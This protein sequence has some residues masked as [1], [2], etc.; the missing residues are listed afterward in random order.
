MSF[1]NLVAEDIRLVILK[2]LEQDV[3]YSHNEYVIKRALEYFGHNVSTDRCRTE[4]KWLEEQG[5]VTISV[6]DTVWI[7]KL[8]ARGEDAALGRAFVHGVKRPQP[9]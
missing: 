1:A 9:V 3:D 6:A 2:S 7:V 4:L 8:T 5:L